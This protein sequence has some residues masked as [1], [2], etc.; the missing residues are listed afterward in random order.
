[1]AIRSM[2]RFGYCSLWSFRAVCWR[3]DDLII[4]LTGDDFYSWNGFIIDSGIFEIQTKR[5][6]IN[7]LS[8]KSNSGITSFILDAQVLFSL[9]HLLWP[10]GNCCR[11][12]LDEVESL[13]LDARS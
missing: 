7:L 3:K 9:P 4:R 1:M 13:K 5:F 10:P 8:D 2:G 6:L 11:P 12:Y